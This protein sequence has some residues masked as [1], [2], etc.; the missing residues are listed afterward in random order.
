MLELR[1][2]DKTLYD[3][4]SETFVEIPGCS[5][6]FE[7]SLVSVSKWES[8]WEKPFLASDEKTPDEL[9]DY[10]HCML[11]N[12]APTAALQSMWPSEL[13]AI[14]RYIAKASTATTVASVP[15]GGSRSIVTSEVIYGWM[16]AYR[17]PWEAQHWHLNRLLTLIRVC[18]A[19]QNPKKK[20]RRFDTYE[21]RMA[22][23][24][25]RQ[26]EL[27]TKG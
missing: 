6:K 2:A 25:K 9:M 8:R 24:L 17:I 21:D 15:S 27:G 14:N 11:L 3:E 16:V 23:N 1:L 19:Q 7:H 12:D 22:L 13:E 20:V 26:K 10:I 18:D 4:R 5:A